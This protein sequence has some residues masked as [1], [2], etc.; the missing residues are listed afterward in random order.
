MPT[1]ARRNLIYSARTAAYVAV[2]N[3]GQ[4]APRAVPV[5]MKAARNAIGT[6]EIS[7]DLLRA[8]VW[9]AIWTAADGDD[10][11]AEHFRI[12]YSISR[13]A[14]VDMA[15]FNALEYLNCPGVLY[16]VARALAWF[17]IADTPR[18]YATWGRVYKDYANS[19]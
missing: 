1:L 4:P 7:N 12:V 19:D 6:M 17:A 9:D 13:D 5:A 14:C 18:T 15:R 10:W 3:Q 16:A 11:A 8:A 2:W